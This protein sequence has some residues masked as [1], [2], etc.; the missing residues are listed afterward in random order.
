VPERRAAD[1]EQARAAETPV[2]PKLLHDCLSPADERHV[3]RGPP[4]H[5]CGAIDERDHL[6]PAL[7]PHVARLRGS[8]LTRPDAEQVEYLE[9]RPLRGV[10]DVRQDAIEVVG[11]RRSSRQAPRGTA[12][13]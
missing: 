3:M 12:G 11:A 1:V 8:Q 5:L 2:P 7:G 4:L 10:V 9:K 6:L 13:T